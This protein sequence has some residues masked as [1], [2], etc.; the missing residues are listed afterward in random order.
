MTEAAKLLPEI[1]WCEGPYDP[2]AGADALVVLTEWNVFRGLDLDRLK[3]EMRTPLLIDLRNIFDPEQV[4]MAGFAY[5]GIGRA[6][7][8]AAT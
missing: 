8:P 4:A 1:D 5:T 7:P 6:A 3:R 2:A